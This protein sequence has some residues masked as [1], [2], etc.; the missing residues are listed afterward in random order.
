MWNFLYL[1]GLI[2][3]GQLTQDLVHGSSIGWSDWHGAEF[4]RW[5][6]NGLEPSISEINS[7]YASFN[8]HKP[9]SFRPSP[10]AVH[11]Q[12]KCRHKTSRHAA[13][14][15][16]CEKPNTGNSDRTTWRKYERWP[17]RQ[18]GLSETQPV[19]QWRWLGPIPA[20]GSREE[21]APAKST[22]DT[23]AT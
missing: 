2:Q 23:P 6:T 18:P 5:A 22:P 3:N 14:D 7:P 17:E 19:M 1:Q 15:I 20:A 10:P 9:S 13:A 8:P 12:R 16:S 11:K 21:C 4:R